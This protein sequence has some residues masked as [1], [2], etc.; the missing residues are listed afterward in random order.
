VADKKLVQL[1]IALLN[2][3]RE[4][5][6]QWSTT[7]R[8]GAFLAQLVDGAVG[9]RKGQGGV[10]HLDIFD[11]KGQVAET[12]TD[13]TL[14]STDAFEPVPALSDLYEAARMS[15]TGADRIVAG[16]LDALNRM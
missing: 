14:Q 9:I 1:V 8:D 2:R 16:L 5:K 4:R 15:S 13:Q 7:S 10:L 3:T 12:V 11:P 6:L